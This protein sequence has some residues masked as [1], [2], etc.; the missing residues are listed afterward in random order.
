MILAVFV[1]FPSAGGLDESVLIIRFPNH[2]PQLRGKQ[3]EVETNNL[4]MRELVRK[5]C[6]DVSK[7]V[8]RW[9]KKNIRQ[10]HI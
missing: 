1:R 8:L 4:V 2:K 6:L 3:Q 5:D 7:M 10:D 9:K